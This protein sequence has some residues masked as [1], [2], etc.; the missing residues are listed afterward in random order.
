MKS[1]YETYTIDDFLSAHANKLEPLGQKSE[2]ARQIIRICN[3]KTDDGEDLV[4]LHGLWAH[5]KALAA[6]LSVHSFL[7]CP[8]IVKWPG[9]ADISA[10]FVGMAERGYVI[11]E[12]TFARISDYGDPDGILSLARLPMRKPGDFP[13]KTNDSVVFVLDGLVKPGNVGVILRS[14]DGAGVDA[15]MTCHLRTRVT[16]PNA[17]KASMGAAFTVPIVPFAHAEACKAWL[18]RN[19]Y[20]I[21]IADPKVETRYDQLSYAGKIAVVMGNEHAGASGAW[22]DGSAEAF[23]IPMRGACDSLNVS[24]AAA[25]LAYEIQKKK[26]GARAKD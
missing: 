23:A 13:A 17:V 18:T 16:H 3:G 1:K 20:A 5:E 12:R 15:V 2:A 24:V 19:G 14:C 9:A 21:Y 25:I 10:R 6:G 8:A 7:I 11:S 22:Y 4:V 26:A